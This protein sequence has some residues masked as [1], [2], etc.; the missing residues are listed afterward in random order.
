MST[1]RELSHYQPQHRGEQEAEEPEESR[2]NED[3]D[4]HWV[5]C[6]RE[7]KQGQGRPIGCEGTTEKR[8]SSHVEPSYS[9]E[10]FWKLSSNVRKIYKSTKILQEINR[11]IF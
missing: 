8:E 6:N 2:E 7:E 11:T 9:T 4:L 5:G 1:H 10:H 3:D